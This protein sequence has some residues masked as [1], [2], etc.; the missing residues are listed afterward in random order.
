MLGERVQKVLCAIVESYISMPL[1]V[2]SMVITKR[3]SFS[4][5]P[6]TIRH[7]MADLEGKGFLSQPHTSAGRV[8]TDKGYRAYVDYLREKGIGVDRELYD[9]LKRNLE[10]LSDLNIALSKVT[11]ALS[12]LS[13]CLAF[14]AP[15]GSAITLNRIQLYRYRGSQVVAVVLSNEGIIKNKVIETDFGLSQKDLSRISDYLNSEF[16]GLNIEEI[17]LTLAEQVS[18]EKAFCD[19]LMSKAMVLCREALSFSFDDVFMSGFSGL[20]TELLGVPGLSS[21]VKDI[22]R[23]I[24]DK[25]FILKLL[26]GLSCPQEV[27][28][29]IGSENSMNEMKGLSV[30]FAPYKQGDKSLGCLGIIGPTR[31]NYS[32]TIPMVESAVGTISIAISGGQFARG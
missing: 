24:E 27:N 19:I 17:R 15:L 2:G 16:S 11:S 22:V 18:K 7:I 14:A 4:L 26:E 21:R 30:V 28:V 6:A 9:I 32:K 10:T 20:L 23:T 3:Y 31:M 5:S 1:P 25:K 13:H 8:P 12:S 29:I